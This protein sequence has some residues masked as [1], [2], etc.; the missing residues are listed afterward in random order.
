MDSVLW[1]I[2]GL[3]VASG[4]W[5]LYAIRTAQ[6]PEPVEQ[7]P[8][9]V[10]PMQGWQKLVQDQQEQAA[11]RRWNAL[12]ERAEERRAREALRVKAE[13]TRRRLRHG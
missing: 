3:V 13:Q 6:Q 11:L 5:C 10:V 4:G 8:S 1:F 7:E 12:V 2:G 9:V